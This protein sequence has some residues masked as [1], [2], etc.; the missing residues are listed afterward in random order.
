MQTSQTIKEIGKEVKLFDDFDDESLSTSIWGTAA[1]TGST[2]VTESSSA[3][4][5]LRIYNPGTGT[6][7]TG[8]IHSVLT[9]GRNVS[10][11][12]KIEVYDGE[13][14][15]DGEQCLARI[16]LYE[17]SDNYVYFGPYRDTS[18]AINSRGYITYNIDNA[19]A[20][21]VDADTTN[22]DNIAREYRID[23][24]E[25]NILFYIDDIL[26]YT[27]KN[28][29]LNNF[30]IRPYGTTQ[31]NTDVIDIRFDYVKV[32]RLSEE[33]RVTY[34]KLLQIQGG[35]DSIG[36]L[37]NSLNSTM[38]MGYAVGSVTP[39]DGTEND[40]YNDSDDTAFKHCVSLIDLTNSAADD[41]VKIREYAKVDSSTEVMFAE[42]TYTG[43][44]TIKGIRVNAGE[45]I[46]GIRIALVQ[47]AA[48]TSYKTYKYLN[49][50]EM[51]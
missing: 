39:T 3:P 46:Y 18:A 35:T 2:T 1:V 41:E 23:V 25:E 31:N 12:S 24:T 16:Q 5:T 8:Y 22:L 30:Y 28:A 51:A 7:G 37:V 45:G 6:T 14:A 40:I 19:G 48:G 17:D 9:F 49:V 4:N 26:I 42:T 47:N 43:V 38:D 11:R 32:L 13:A 10:V 15:G 36:T 21:T 50:D 20:T 33:D 44:Q 34:K 29:S 27:L